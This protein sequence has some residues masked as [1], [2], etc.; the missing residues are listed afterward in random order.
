[1][2]FKKGDEVLITGGKDRGKKGKVDR[3][4]PQEDAVIVPGLNLYKRHL[5]KRDE[6]N[7]GG[8]I[9]FPRPIPV[10]RIALICPKCRKPTRIGYSVAGKEKQRVC[11][12]C[13]QLI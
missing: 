2:K 13:N 1:M 11:R 9:E 8:I 5:K 7:Q 3:L 10:G 12:K 4:L 6:K